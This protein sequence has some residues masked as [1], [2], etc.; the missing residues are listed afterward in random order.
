MALATL[1]MLIAPGKGKGVQPEL[2]P[3]AA[4]QSAPVAPPKAAPAAP[5]GKAS[6]GKAPADKPAPASVR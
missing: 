6:G 2:A 5:G 4:G 1:S 3:V